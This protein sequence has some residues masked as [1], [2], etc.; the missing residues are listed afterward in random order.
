MNKAQHLTTYKNNTGKLGV[1]TYSQ[2][3]N[4]GCKAESM[5]GQSRTILI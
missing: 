2:F 3:V 4:F 5:S 1:V